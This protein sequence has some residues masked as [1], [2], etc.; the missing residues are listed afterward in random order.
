MTGVHYRKRYV[1]TKTISENESE[2]TVWNSIIN[3]VDDSIFAWFSF[4]PSR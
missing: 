1:D 4:A 3:N 2:T